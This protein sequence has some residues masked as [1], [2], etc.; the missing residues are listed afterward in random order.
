MAGSN[1]ALIVV[2]AISHE[3]SAAFIAADCCGFVTGRGL[4]L[5]VTFFG[6][7]RAR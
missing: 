2:A 4:S 5:R 6:L 7:T 3:E 1:T